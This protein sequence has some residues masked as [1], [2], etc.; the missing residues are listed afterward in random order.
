MRFKWISAAVL[1]AACL[2][3]GVVAAT[4]AGGGSG[5]AAGP[6]SGFIPSRNVNH[7][8]AR[9]RRVL[10]LL[11]HNGPVMHSTTVVPVYWGT[12]W[13]NSSF[14]GDKVTGLDTLYSR[15]GGTRVCAHERRVHRRRRQRQHD[16]HLEGRR[17]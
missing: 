6:A 2:V 14:V 17:T 5:M 16:E 12:R 15:V 10:Q 4:A 9:A 7:Q 8:Q 13:G 11:W 1:A 3:S